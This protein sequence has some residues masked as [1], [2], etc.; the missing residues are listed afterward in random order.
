[1][2]YNKYIGNSLEPEPKDTVNRGRS[3]NFMKIRVL[4]YFLAVARE[5]TVSAAAEALHLTQPTLSRQLRELEDE[6]GKKLFERGAHTIKLTEEGMLLR[7]RAE[8]IVELVSRTE[9]DIMTSDDMLSGDVYIGAGETDAVKYIAS[10]AVKM[11]ADL[12]RIHFH[13]YSG[14]GEHILGRLDKGLCDFGIIFVPVDDSKYHSIKMPVRDEWGILMRRDS[15]LAA[16]QKIRLSDIW[17]KPVIIS[18]QRSDKTPMYRWFERYADKLDVVSTY[19]LVFNASIMVREGLG[20]ALTLDKLINVS[21]DSDLCFRPLDPP[22]YA[23]MNF[24][25][26]KYQP[27]TKTAEKFLE[28]FRAEIG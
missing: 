27:M 16:K 18:R 4:R 17:D 14:D 6:L 7:S 13:I 12:P 1:M 23:E 20:Y 28:Y 22:V 21:G 24:V 10:A 8:Q 5:G 26:N 15:E 9:S 11:Q 25:W 2:P 19:N 3:H